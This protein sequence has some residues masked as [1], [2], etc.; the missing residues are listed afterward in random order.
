MGYLPRGRNFKSSP[1]G[2]AGKYLAQKAMK[3]VSVYLFI[4]HIFIH[5]FFNHSKKRLLNI[6]NDNLKGE[7]FSN[8]IEGKK[9]Q[10][11][12]HP[13]SHSQLHTREIN[14]KLYTIS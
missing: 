1:E 11:L 8:N 2:T 4:I 10:T 13:E 3:I 5:I 9:P 6:S 7:R 14:K 12:V